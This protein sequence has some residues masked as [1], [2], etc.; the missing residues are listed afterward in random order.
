MIKTPSGDK[1]RMHVW[2][3]GGSSDTAKNNAM[4]YAEQL[5]GVRRK[6]GD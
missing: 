5:N 2:K 6:K 3:S 4:W 1:F